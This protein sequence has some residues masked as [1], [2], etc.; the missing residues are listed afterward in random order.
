M[1]IVNTIK[2]DNII[3]FD[4]EIGTYLC[5]HG[6]SLLTMKDGRFVFRNT[7][8]FKE[9]L[10]TIPKELLKTQKGGGSI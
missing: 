6:A 1:F 10:K 8:N 4:Y 9:I 7:K 2:L 3:D 5:T